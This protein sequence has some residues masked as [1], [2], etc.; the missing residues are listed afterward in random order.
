M[1]W[2]LSNKTEGFTIDLS[3]LTDLTGGDVQY[4]GITGVH[5][6]Q[7]PDHLNYEVQ[8]GWGNSTIDYQ[9]DN[10]NLGQSDGIPITG[11]AIGYENNTDIGDPAISVTPC[12]T[13]ST[14]F[15]MAGCSEKCAT[16][17][18]VKHSM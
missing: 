14:T 4:S 12:D 2:F 5:C 3:H 13:S 15:T 1:L 8:G 9:S 6:E 16:P 18:G 7:P 10:F 17:T 11:C